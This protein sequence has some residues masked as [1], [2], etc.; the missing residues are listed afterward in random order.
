MKAK[1]II[2][3]DLEEYAKSQGKTDIKEVVHNLQMMLSGAQRGKFNSEQKSQYF[4]AWF[5]LQILNNT[6]KV[7]HNSKE[8]GEFIY[9]DRMFHI[10]ELEDGPQTIRRILYNSLCQ[11]PLEIPDG[12]ISMRYTFNNSILDSHFALNN[13][14]CTSMIK[15]MTCAFQNATFVKGFTF[16]YNFDISNVKCMYGMFKNAKFTDGFKLPKQ[17]N[18]LNGVTIKDMFEGAMYGDQYLGDRDPITVIQ[19]LTA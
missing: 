11:L 19:E 17:F 18:G 13:Q 14:V 10:F 16:G 9:D 2:K 5:A 1:D 7:Y 12:L 6:H 3:Q 8:L 15:D 4:Q